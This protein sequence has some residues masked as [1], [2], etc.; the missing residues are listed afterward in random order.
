MLRYVFGYSLLLAFI[1]PGVSL[2]DE[3]SI[4]GAD[5]VLLNGHIYTADSTHSMAQAIAV[6]GNI[7]TAVGTDQ[8]ISQ[9]ITPG[10]TVHDLKGR[11]ILPGLHDS[12][13]HPFGIVQMDVC[14]LASQP[15]ALKDIVHQLKGC[16]ARYSIPDGEWLIVQ[17]W[18]FSEGNQPSEKYPSLRVALD[19]VSTV[20]PI[21]LR[22]NDGHHGAA[23]SLAM[24]RAADK[25]GNVLG[26]SQATLA[27]E[28]APYRELVGVDA[29]GQPNGE[30]N[31]GAREFMN[32]PAEELLYGGEQMRPYMP[33][34]AAKFASYGITSV[35][36]A[37]I[38]PTA[39]DL[40]RELED[41]QQ[42]TFRLTAAMHPDWNQY[43]NKNDGSIDL[44]KIVET[45]KAKRSSLASS[46][47]IKADTVKLFADGVIEGNPFGEPPTLPNAAVLEPYKQPL[48]HFDKVSKSLVLDGYV[49]LD[50]DLC[51]AVRAKS[52]EQITEEEKLAFRDKNGFLPAQ[53]TLS[54]GVL[55]HDE[56][57][58]RNYVQRM[59][60]AGFGVHI[61]VIGDRAARVALDAFEF[62]RSVNGSTGN[63][64][65]L[66]H[67][68]LLH[69]DDAV[70]LG[71]LGVYV[72]FTYGWILPNRPYDLTVVP[73]LEQMASITDLYTPN[74][75][76]YLN[77]YPVRE[78]QQLGGVL[79]G[80]SDAPVDT[81]EPLPFNH[82]EQA[83]TR[84]NREG[85]VFNADQAVDIYSAVDA[86]TI[87]GAR[88]LR[89]ADS[90]G[91][92]EAGKKA[93]L[94]VVNQNI[95]E[96]ASTGRAKDISETLVDLTIFD[97]KVVY[98][99]LID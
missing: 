45:F 52:P 76:S 55:E 2:A 62:A 36:D 92:L 23:N 96:L 3:S 35:M 57:F 12:H 97:G 30:V 32:P 17:Q 80:G 94:V 73:F 72:A 64:Y 98:Q 11:L 19:A 74:Q 50:S 77:S 24:S 65:S 34:I 6:T 60:A 85:E 58:I 43:R 21:L 61:H 81:R 59:D 16:L 29:N 48:L 47:Y 18:A 70:R 42:L 89:Q 20:H 44:E 87:N 63:P 4:S 15:L 66:A 26:F 54:N 56:T 37:A 8:E 33:E 22:G 99:R 41:K 75:Y 95:F 82:I 40:Y 68:Q 88:M 86:Y 67:L 93:D 14:D 84:A 5:I 79:A 69:P 53:C 91:S 46:S 10:T 51:N 7:I 83:I 78:I 90:V 38:V 13:I 9:Y 49:R 31:E 71:K 27:A 25:A 28:F 39:I 1:L